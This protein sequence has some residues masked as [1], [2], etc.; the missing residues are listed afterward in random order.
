MDLIA[1]GKVSK[2]IGTRGEVK[3][4]PLT[5]EMQRFVH[6]HSVYL[7]YHEAKTELINILNVRIDS[8]Q[9]VLSVQGIE[10]VEEAKK[11]T[12]CYLL[13]QKENAVQLKDGCYFI[14]DVIGCEVLTEEQKNVGVITDLLTLPM[15]DVWVV[16]KGTKEFL[17]PAVKSI[18]R[19][20]DIEN[21]CVTIH[22]LDGLLD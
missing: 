18:I 7:G 5:D 2:P 22:A 12:G 21:K 13:V 16:R 8:R 11:I 6:L 20:V 14:D 10:T 19:Q 4:L 17:I 1:I 3:I 9:I 15:N